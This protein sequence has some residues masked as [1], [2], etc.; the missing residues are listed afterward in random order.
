MNLNRINKLQKVLA[1]KENLFPMDSEYERLK[2]EDMDKYIRK[3]LDEY[4]KEHKLKSVGE[5]VEFLQW[6]YWNGL[7][8]KDEFKVLRKGEQEFWKVQ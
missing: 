2:S 4:H 3:Q 7:I 5:A 8:T 1:M 6:Q